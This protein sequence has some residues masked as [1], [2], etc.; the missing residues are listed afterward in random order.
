VPS[1][2]TDI[3]LIPV[4]WLEAARTGVA[5]LYGHTSHGSQLVT[6]AEFLRDQID[7]VLYN[8]R[9]E[10]QAFPGQTD[11]PALLVVDDDDWAWEPDNFL[12]RARG[13]LNDPSIGPYVNVF[14]WSWC[15]QM[16][17]EG[18]DVQVYLDM[19][20]Q[21][22]SEY[23]QIRFVFMTGHTDGGSDIQARNNQLVRDWVDANGG[24]LYDFADIESWDP[25]GRH[26][27]ST[28]DSCPWC[29]DWCA[30]HPDQC[31]GLP[32]FDDGC[33]HTWGFNC[34]LKGQAFWWLAARLAGWNGV[35]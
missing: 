31:N 4:E 11:P 25:A 22:E 24:I 5:V 7:P 2:L 29:P 33:A 18:T 19:M 9:S 12:E 8:F 17:E 35:P 16:S 15:G 27:P 1:S 13:Y 6:G 30:A 10:W 23:P 20:T 34:R 26:Y 32:G 14:L 21:L 3:S 28:D